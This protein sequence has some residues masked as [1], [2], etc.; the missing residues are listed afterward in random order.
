MEKDI[1]FLIN[2]NLQTIQAL[3]EKN[4]Q[5]IC[6]I[7]KAIIKTYN[8]SGTVFVFGNGG[9]AADSQHMVA[10]LVGRFK[11]ERRAFAAVA[12]TTNTSI[13]TALANDY[14]YDYV[15]ERQIEA[16]GKKNDIVIGISTSG[17][18]KNV[19]NGFKKARSLGLSCIAFT[20]AKGTNLIE[21]C[22]ICLIVPS[23]NTPRIQE[24]HITAIHIICKLVEDA[25]SP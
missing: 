8:N 16:L 12:L 20:G 5:V 13:L 11:K 9:S 19:I 25:L 15:F 14:S 4:S 23:D 22:D 3:R 2:E 6:E 21:L 17:K 24:A 1:Q 10:E 18:A 7:A